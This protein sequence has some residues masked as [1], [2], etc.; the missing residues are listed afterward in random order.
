MQM[1][2]LWLAAAL[3]PLLGCV[4]PTP[5]LEGPDTITLSTTITNDSGTAN[6]VDA[7]I[8]LDS[9]QVDESCPA[10]L[11]PETDAN[12]NITG[13]DCSAAPSTSESLTA[14]SSIGPGSHR[15][16]FHLLTLTAPVQP[17]P[18]TVAG[19]TV[20][21]YDMGGNLLKTIR[22]PA[23][24]ATLGSTDSWSIFYSFGF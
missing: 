8:I 9:V 18:Y 15:L 16:E 5:V 10:D 24:T 17:A 14:M 3:G 12:G 19:F 1:R 21:V 13:E 23:Q 7:Q 20:Q 4:P 22:L 6:I 11:S 2:T